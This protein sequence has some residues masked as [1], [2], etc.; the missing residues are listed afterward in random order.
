MPGPNSAPNGDRRLVSN[1][2]VCSTHG[3]DDRKCNDRCSYVRWRDFLATRNRMVSGK[4][5][6][7]R[8]KA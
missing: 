3:D 2:M 6:A 1:E 7:R 4:T 8:R 5:A